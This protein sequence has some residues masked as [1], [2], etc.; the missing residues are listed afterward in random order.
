MK[1]F[2][3]VMVLHVFGIGGMND[4]VLDR[5]RSH[6]GELASNKAICMELN[7]ALTV[8]QRTSTIHLGYLGAVQTIMANHTA[9]PINKLKT[10]KK[11]RQLIEESIQMDPKNAELRFIRLSIQKKAPSFLGYRGNIAEDAAY[12]RKY[13]ETIASQMV[14][15]NVN[16]LLAEK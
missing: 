9:N 7:Q 4:P 8:S 6:Y 5:V 3:L 10:F 15:K 16:E 1:V 12:L 11:G 2:L 13:K 14:R